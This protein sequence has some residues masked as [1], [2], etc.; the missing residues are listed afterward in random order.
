MRRSVMHSRVWTDMFVLAL[1][2]VEKSL[3][4]IAVYFFLVIGLRLAG[5]KELAQLNPFDLVVVLTLSNTIHNALIGADNNVT[6]G[7]TG[8]STLLLFNYIVVRFL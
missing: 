6:G 7:N 1:P 3:R 2:V 8:A 4:P 5:K